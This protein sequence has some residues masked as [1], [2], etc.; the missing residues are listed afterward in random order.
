MS[1]SALMRMV[2]TNRKGKGRDKKHH[3]KKSDVENSCRFSQRCAKDC[4]VLS[5][6]WVDLS[7]M[8]EESKT[9]HPKPE[10]RGRGR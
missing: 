10:A 9:A 7:I 5:E 2:V 1:D 6:W 3:E 8:E 4:R